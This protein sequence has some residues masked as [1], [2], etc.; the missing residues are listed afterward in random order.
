M[1]SLGLSAVRLAE[2]T[3]VLLSQ[4]DD[5]DFRKRSLSRQQSRG[6]YE[7]VGNAASYLLDEIFQPVSQELFI[8]MAYILR[9]FC[10]SNNSASK[11]HFRYYK[12]V[13]L[14]HV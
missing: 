6:T 14:P 3:F 2:V 12:Y 4:P 13:H 1:S 10:M 8:F 7:S 5:S 11:S 9:K